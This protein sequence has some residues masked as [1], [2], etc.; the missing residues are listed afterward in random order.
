MAA[1]LPGHLPDR[2]GQCRCG[3]DRGLSQ[4]AASQQLAALERRVGL[5]LFTRTSAGVEP[6]R[7]GRELHAQVADSL[8]RL[9]PVLAGLDGGSLVGPDAP[10]RFGSSAEFFAHALGRLLGPDSP[11]L[12][13]RFGP[14]DELVRLVDQGEL[15]LAVTS[16]TPGRR[17]LSS[18]L[19]G[20]RRFVLVAPPAMA[21]T[22]PFDSLADLGPW[23]V[24]RPWVAYSAELPLTRRFWLSS[25]GRTFGGE[26]RLVAPD[27]RVVAAAVAQG[28]GVSLL[29][30]FV[31]A[32]ALER[33]A[34][35]ELFPVGGVVP[36][37]PWF[38]CTR[39]ADTG[40]RRLTRL[41]EA[42]TSTAGPQPQGAQP[43]TA[44]TGRPSS[45]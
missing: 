36:T 32:E 12:S 8:D 19:I 23:L 18:V 24:G 22:D 9:E 14:D 1:H 45:R 39:V 28:L 20:W 44:G 16:S 13:A 40:Q 11:G 33:G 26:L 35:V 7:R 2:L 6:T 31:C 38:A 27:L 17:S 43:G 34:V 42:M 30:D 3:P 15:D 21:P 4:P 41:V 5:P 25:L 37:E 10:V 29:P